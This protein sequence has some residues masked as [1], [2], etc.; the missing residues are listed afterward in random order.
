MHG[1]EDNN[2]V[3]ND[4]FGKEPEIKD[5]GKKL[6]IKEKEDSKSSDLHLVSPFES[7]DEQRRRVM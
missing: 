4:Q 7:F 2:A 5:I 1:D 6:E 3:A